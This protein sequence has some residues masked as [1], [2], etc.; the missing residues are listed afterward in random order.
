ML[1]RRGPFAEAVPEFSVRAEQ[2]AMAEA[3]EIAISTGSHLVCEAGTGVGKTYA[4]LVPALLAWAARGSK[5]I[6]STGTKALQEQLF[7]RDLPAVE[8][9][10]GITGLQKALLKGRA[11]YVCRYRLARPPSGALPRALAADFSRIET[12]SHRTRVGDRGELASV[13]E[14][15]PAWALATSDAASCHGTKCEH[16]DECY[17]FRAR[18][19]ALATDFLVVNH[20]LLFADIGLREEGFGELLPEA[21]A[22]V[23]DEAHLAPEI[24]TRF[25]GEWVST[26]A[27]VNLADEARAA[28]RDDD[29]AALADVDALEA[30]ARDVRAKLPPGRRREGWRALGGDKS[31]IPA[32]SMLRS[33]LEG[34]ALMLASRRERDESTRQAAERSADLEARLCRVLDGEE[35]GDFVTWVETTAR[36]VSWNRTPL[37]IASRLAPYLGDGGASWI[38]TSATVTASGSFRHFT[39]RMGLEEAEALSLGSPFDYGCQMLGYVPRGLPDPRAA[40]FHAALAD[41]VVPVLEA[42]GGRAFLLFTSH[43][44]MERCLG[45]L[46]GR[47]P[48]PLLVQGRAPRSELLERFRRLGNAVLLGTASFWQGVDVRGGSLGCVVIDKLPFASPQDPV[49]AARMERCRRAG[50]DP[51]SEI[52]LPEAILTL[53]QGVGR[54][55]RDEVARGV[56]MFGDRRLMEAGYGHKFVESL[57]ECPMTRELDAVRRFFAP[58]SGRPAGRPGVLG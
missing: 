30:A 25:F 22:V 9:A 47:L 18:R 49:L 23:V 53:K 24:A 12:W 34:V 48:H 10:L 27:V 43:L 38:F 28:L 41:A 29:P 54:L 4:Y 44:G 14:T 40:G 5:V 50:G 57:P 21:D 58:D 20:H 35:E 15:S 11:N 17:V 6:V 55:I 2:Q 42:S 13:P 32:V 46:Q 31:I 56:V 37:D 16:F 33:A 1:G 36:N 7:F 51:F 52:Q 26:Q 3:V 45:S 19:R 8:G 39:G